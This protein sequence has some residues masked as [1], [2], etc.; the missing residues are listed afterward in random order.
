MRAEEPTWYKAKSGCVVCVSK[1]GGKWHLSI[2]HRNRL[3]TY[4]ELKEARYKYLPDVK[5]MAQIFPPKGE[6][7]NVCETC[8]HLWEIDPDPEL[9]KRGGSL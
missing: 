6:F 2:S 4:E 1:D 5:Y 7:V 8:L 9:D 3:P